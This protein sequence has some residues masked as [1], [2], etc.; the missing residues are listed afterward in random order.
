MARYPREGVTTTY[1][2]LGIAA[3]VLLLIFISIYLFRGRHEKIHADK[4][5]SS[6]VYS[7]AQ[8]AGSWS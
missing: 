7:V 3:F 4:P 1:V 2:V 8:E 5:Q 6:Y